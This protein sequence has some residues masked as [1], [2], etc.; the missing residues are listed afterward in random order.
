MRMDSDSFLTH[1]YATP[2]LACLHEYIR[3]TMRS[4]VCLSTFAK[5][6]YTLQGNSRAGGDP[7]LPQHRS[8][9]CMKN[10]KPMVFV[11]QINMATTTTHDCSGLLPP[12]GT[13]FFFFGDELPS[14]HMEHAVIYAPEGVPLERT[15]PH[16]TPWYVASKP[17]LFGR[18]ASPSPFVGMQLQA[19][20]GV[21]IAS[22]PY[23]ESAV[24]DAAEELENDDE[25]EALPDVYDA[26]ARQL[27][28]GWLC[29][30]FGYGEEQNGDLEYEAALF[31]H[32]QKAYDC[33]PRNA[34]AT[35]A[36]HFKGNRVRAKQAIE[37]TLLLLEVRSHEDVGFL[38]GYNGV[39]HFC[40]DRQ[41]LLDRR[42]ERTYVN[43]Y[44]S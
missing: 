21:D 38:W 16:E 43:M 31:L 10:G 8:W 28:T 3:S 26:F 33:F 14:T 12:N 9:P 22:L 18:V 40:I 17:E 30:C 6:D 5:E 42:F 1:L 27:N 25:A 37:D 34:L 39:L 11:A 36:E 24:E 32:T 35:L 2:D 4:T 23:A 15:Q 19:Y 44:Y 13:L 41:D 20:G 29:K 7:D